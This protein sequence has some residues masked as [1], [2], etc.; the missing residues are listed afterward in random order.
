[1]RGRR[2]GHAPPPRAHGRVHLAG[3]WE[4]SYF[5]DQEVVRCPGLSWADSSGTVWATGRNER[6]G[7]CPP[8]TWNQTQLYFVPQSPHLSSEENP[9]THPTALLGPRWGCGLVAVA[10]PLLSAFRNCPS[11]TPRDSGGQ[12]ND[13]QGWAP[14]LAP[15]ITAGRAWDPSQASPEPS[16]DRSVSRAK[17]MATTA[18]VPRLWRRW[19]RREE[20]PASSRCMRPR[21]RRPA[22]SPLN[23]RPSSLAEASL[24]RVPATGCCLAYYSKTSVGD[25]GYHFLKMIEIALDDPAQRERG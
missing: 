13:L 8:R 25:S 9:G 24:H 1:M 12:S 21:S 17:G 16:L 20:R 15:R 11:S 6:G 19:P 5:F 10:L 3:S 22:L 18:C 23:F 2:R 4:L 7:E 14:G